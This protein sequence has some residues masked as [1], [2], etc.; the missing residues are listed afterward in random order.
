MGAYNPVSYHNGSVWPHDTAIVATGLMRYGFVK[1]ASRVAEALFSAAEYF[2]DRLPELFCGFDR[3]EFAQPVP[4]PTACSPQAWAAAAPVQLARALLRFDP[5]FTRRV[6]HLA[7]ILPEEFGE[8]RADNVLLGRSR[9]T[10]HAQDGSGSIEE[11]P[12]DL[13]LRMTPR[14]PLDQGLFE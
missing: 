12:G 5:D 7:P 13:E 6:V 14:P 8:F 4:Y 3:S 10:I 11:L 9:I 1:E 2:G